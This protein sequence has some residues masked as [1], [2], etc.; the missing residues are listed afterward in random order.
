[1]VA[2][3]KEV[4]ANAP[5]AVDAQPA[6]DCKGAPKHAPRLLVCAQA[7]PVAEEVLTFAQALTLSLDGQ[8]CLLSP[9]GGTLATCDAI[10][11]QAE[12]HGYDLVIWGEPEQSLSQRLLS[13]PAYQRVAERI[14]T[15]LLVVRNPCWPLRRLLLV[16]V[17]EKFE[18]TAVDWVIRLARPNEA[19]V[20]ALAVVPPVPAMYDQCA[21]MQQGLDALLTTNTALGRQLRR[22]SQRLV[23]WGVRGTLRLRQGEP[24]V[25][26]Q[27]EVAEGD[28]DLIVATIAPRKRWQRWLT[29]NQVLSLLRWADRPVLAVKPCDR[30]FGSAGT[31]ASEA[32]QARHDPQRLA[33]QRLHE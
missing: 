16:V 18:D 28:Y 14:S 19:A 23:D 6:S 30:V 7:S 20:T 1:M 25:Q 31:D 2:F 29:E 9:L 24:N 13:G 3:P 27:C 8:L 26:I 4:V 10:A 17:G 11:Q 15:S 21:R 33:S 5:L 32:P 12:Q 22:A